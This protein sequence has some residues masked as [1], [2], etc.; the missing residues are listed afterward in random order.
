MLTRR[1]FAAGLAASTLAGCAE[2][3][4]DPPEAITKAQYSS[5]GPPS[6]SLFTN[7]RVATG[8][9]AHTALLIDGPQRVVFDP[10]GS[11]HHPETPRINDLHYG[12]TPRMET[13]FIDYHARSTYFV[14]R[15]TRQVSA[16]T[17]AIAL[18][19]AEKM[20]RVIDLFCTLRTCEILAPLPGFDGFPKTMFPDAASRAFG[21]YPGVVT[22]VFTDDSPG[23]RGDIGG[24]GGTGPAG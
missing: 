18:A 3:L 1:S 8:K 14:R 22:E 5:G 16:E 7:V 19:E 20:P 2:P 12:M 15:Q 13:W 23:N 10:A 21:A 4:R 17:A 24:V 11:Y 6:L 9:G